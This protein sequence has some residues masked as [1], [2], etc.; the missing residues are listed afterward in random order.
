MVK[1]VGMLMNLPENDPEV[2]ERKLAFQEGFTRK[3]VVFYVRHG[4]GNFPYDEAAKQLVKLNPDVFFATC[5]P[6]FWALQAKTK[7]SIVYAAMIDPNQTARAKTTGI[8]ATGIS[9]YNYGLSHEWVDLLKEMDKRIARVAVIVDLGSKAG[10]GQW[11]EIDHYARGLGLETSWIN[12]ADFESLPEATD[13][14]ARKG[15]G[16]LIVPTGTK[17]ATHRTQIIELA[18]KNKLPAIYAN[19]MYAKSGGLFSRGANTLEIYRSAAGL[20][21]KILNGENAGDPTAN[22]TFQ[23]V[24][25]LSAARAIG[26]T[27]PQSLLNKADEIIP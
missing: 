20:V 26:L 4:G 23:T 24:I 16:G 21:D 11:V 1:R 8:N 27:V 5:G 13:E 12:I 14:I 25:N 7:K 9:S 18:N 6:S 22:K 3:D 19:R 10:R 15:N 2:A 17:S